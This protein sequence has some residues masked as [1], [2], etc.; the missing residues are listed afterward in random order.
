MRYTTR[1][2]AKQWAKLGLKSALIFTDAQLWDAVNDDLRRAAR[3]ITDRLDEKFDG[4]S[5]NMRDAR[6]VVRRGNA[7]GSHALTLAGGI[8]IG[9]ALGVLFAPSSGAE[10]RS[11]IRD[12]VDR[13]KNRVGSDRTGV[14]VFETG[15]TGT[16]GD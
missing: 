13:I 7:W 3:T 5:D 12:G 4:R 14:I 6:L 16:T 10:T 8:G 9:I 11:S 15:S 1:M 2:K